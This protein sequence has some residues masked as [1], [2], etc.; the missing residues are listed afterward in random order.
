MWFATFILFFPFM[1]YQNPKLLATINSPPI[2]KADNEKQSEKF[3]LF[4][5]ISSAFCF[6]V[7]H[8]G[9]EQYFLTWHKTG[10]KVGNKYRAII[11]SGNRGFIF[12]PFFSYGNIPAALSLPNKI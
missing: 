2:C 8:S 9:A 6:S 5:F 12:T 7:A 4:S 3:K 1:V 10:H 11:I